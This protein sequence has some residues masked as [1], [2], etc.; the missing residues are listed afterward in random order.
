MHYSWIA[1]IDRHHP[2]IPIEIP[3][4]VLKNV[5]PGM[6]CNHCHGFNV[7]IGEILMTCECGGWDLVED[8]ILRTVFEYTVLA[9][10]EKVDIPSLL[11]FFN[12]Q[13][14]KEQLDKLLDK[15]AEEII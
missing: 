12:N 4:T 6:V 11:E 3:D 5:V 13:I 2:C 14:S 8:A 7:E 15:I 1:R 9:R 10:G